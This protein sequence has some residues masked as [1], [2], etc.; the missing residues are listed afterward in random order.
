MIGLF[1]PCR[2]G[3]VVCEAT[4]VEEAA[5]ELPDDGVHPVLQRNMQASAHSP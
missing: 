2:D 4:L 3:L 1:G 5:R